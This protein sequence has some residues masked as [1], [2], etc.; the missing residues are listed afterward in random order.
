MGNEKKNISFGHYLKV[1]R[2]DKE[3]SVE[4]ISKNTRIS[5][6]NVLSIENEEHDNLP[7]SIYVRGFLQAYG[8]VLGIDVVSLIE[9]YNSHLLNYLDTKKS[10]D[11]NI[12]T[13][14]V[15]LLK[16]LFLIVFSFSCIIFISLYLFSSMGPE[17]DISD[18]DEI[19]QITDPE[20]TEEIIN[21]DKIFS[22]LSKISS[23]L[24]LDVLAIEEIIVKVIIDGKSPESFNLKIGD[25]ISFEAKNQLNFLASS[26]TG[27]SL[28]FNNKKVEVEG[29]TGQYVSFFYKVK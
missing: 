27:L 29:K 3:Y 23:N 5:L 18:I 7:E 22:N 26:A 28:K 6:S 25:K 15:I 8:R 1:C 12:F 13:S 9:N 2:L 21:K 4:Y 20:K 17:S 14:N 16:N 10:S 11:E 24:V 19:T